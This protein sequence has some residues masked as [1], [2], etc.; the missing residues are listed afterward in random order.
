[1]P[2]RLGFFRRYV[3]RLVRRLGAGLAVF[4]VGLRLIFRVAGIFRRFAGGLVDHGVFLFGGRA[5][6]NRM[7]D[8]EV[9]AK[10]SP[11]TGAGLDHAEVGLAGEDQAASATLA[12]VELCSAGAELR[13]R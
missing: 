12:E 6:F 8:A 11:A 13:I 1:M 5:V 10:K 7:G 2:S 3:L 9:I 4:L